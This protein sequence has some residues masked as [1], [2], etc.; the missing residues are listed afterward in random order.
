MKWIKVHI[1]QREQEHLGYINADKITS[2]HT[3][4]MVQPGA[5]APEGKE[6]QVI[7]TTVT[8]VN[9]EGQTPVFVKESPRQLMNQM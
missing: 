9:I 6:P 8:V 7:E 4:T 5:E 2:I 3:L 1:L